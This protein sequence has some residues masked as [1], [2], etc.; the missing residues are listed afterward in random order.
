MKNYSQPFV[1]Y[2]GCGNSLLDGTNML[3]E[4]GEKSFLETYNPLWKKP[5]DGGNKIA[6]STRNKLKTKARADV[7]FM[8]KYFETILLIAAIMTQMMNLQTMNQE[9]ISQITNQ[10]LLMHQTLNKI[11]QRANLI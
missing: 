8:G 11:Q 10:Q 9:A 3:L 1:K 2:H 6:K 4:T 5:F 7:S